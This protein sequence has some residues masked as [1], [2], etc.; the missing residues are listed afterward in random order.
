MAFQRIE[1]PF[2]RPSAKR[3]SDRR[4][5]VEHMEAVITG[6]RVLRLVPEVPMKIDSVTASQA[7]QMAAISL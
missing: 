3:P 5:S 4:E 7:P 2:A 6:W 1:G